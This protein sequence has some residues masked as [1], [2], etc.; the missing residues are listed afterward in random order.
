MKRVAIMIG[1]G[2][3][4]IEMVSVYDILKRAGV[5]AELISVNDETVTSAHGLRVTS[6]RN[7]KDTELKDYDMIFIPGGKIDNLLKSEELK[8]ELKAFDEKGKMISAICAGPLV[9]E[10]ANILNGR[11]VTSYPGLGDRFTNVNYIGDAITVTDENILT[12]RGPAT[13]PYFAFEILDNLGLQKEAE[14]IFK[15]MQFEFLIE[16][17]EECNEC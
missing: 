4:D 7:I 15:G 6:D 10:N 16:D 9:L 5:S 3:E 14:E 17:P 8:K 13:A 1:N 11:S 12:S 2:F